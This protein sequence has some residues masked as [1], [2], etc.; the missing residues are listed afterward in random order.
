V[1]Q[2][3]FPAACALACGNPHH[4]LDPSIRTDE[5]D[6]LRTGHICNHSPQICRDDGVASTTRPKQQK[7]GKQWH[8]PQDIGMLATLLVISIHVTY[9]MD[10]MII[11]SISG[12]CLG[13]ECVSDCTVLDY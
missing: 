3:L 12:L 1:A 6:R 10:R 11:G 7:L 8:S 13:M 5:L 4:S 2:V 9:Y